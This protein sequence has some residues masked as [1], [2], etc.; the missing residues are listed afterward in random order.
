M[1]SVLTGDAAFIDGACR[2]RKMVGGGLR[3]VGI[4]AAAGLYALQNNVDRLA[5]D[6]ALARELA[7]GLSQLPGLRARLPD[8]NIVF[9]DVDEAIAATLAAFLAEQGIGITSSRGGKSQR[10][11]THMD[12]GGASVKEAL[13]CVGRFLSR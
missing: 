2:L 5:D 6:H 13:K 12:V 7:D 8:T 10:W 9:V 3:Q 11:V 4:I 1:G